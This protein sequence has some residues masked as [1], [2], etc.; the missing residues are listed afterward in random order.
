MTGGTPAGEHQTGEDHVE[1]GLQRERTALAWTRTALS[2]MVAGSLLIE[3][4]GAPFDDVYHLPGYSALSAGAA[5]LW[6]TARD[7]RWR[8]KTDDDAAQLR[9]GRALGV[10]IAAFGLGIASLLIVA[11][12][13]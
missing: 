11:A 2:L 7:Q 13:R 9:P 12:G 6:L 1:D 3:Y 4:L 5:V 10:G 8:A